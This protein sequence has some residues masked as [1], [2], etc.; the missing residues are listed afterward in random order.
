MT[1]GDKTF[2]VISVDEV[3]SKGPHNRISARKRGDIR[4]HALFP[5]APGEDT[6][7]RHPSTSQKES[8]HTNLI[9]QTI[10][11]RMGRIRLSVV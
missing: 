10:S 9:V 7:R 2:D 6:G 5:S 3:I 8:S 11:L 4:E 1:F